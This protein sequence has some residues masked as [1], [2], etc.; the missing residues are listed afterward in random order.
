MPQK[1]S[2]LPYVVLVTLLDMVLEIGTRDLLNLRKSSREFYFLINSYLTPDRVLK[3]L[4]TGHNYLFRF[5]MGRIVQKYTS[6]LGFLKDLELYEHG[7]RKRKDENIV[8]WFHG[9]KPTF[10]Y[11]TR[12]EAEKWLQYPEIRSHPLWWDLSLYTEFNCRF[13]QFTV[14]KEKC[15][16][17]IE[18]YEQTLRYWVHDPD[19]WSFRPWRLRNFPLHHGCP[20]TLPKRCATVADEEKDFQRL[21]DHITQCKRFRLE[22]SNMQAACLSNPEAWNLRMRPEG[23]DFEIPDWSEVARLYRWAAKKPYEYGEVRFVVDNWGEVFLRR[24][25]ETCDERWSFESEIEKGNLR[26]VTGRINGERVETEPG[27]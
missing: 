8:A 11:E 9:L 12:W 3:A 26:V 23:I 15:S 13:S 6:G 19:T 17:M 25:R 27:S 24:R 7:L 20:Y 10:L 16:D 14:F 5:R 1:L 4:C 21:E 2:D 18:S 22:L